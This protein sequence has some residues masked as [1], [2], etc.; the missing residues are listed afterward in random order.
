VLRTLCLLIAPVVD[1]AV[2]KVGVCVYT[3]RFCLWASLRCR[4]LP[5]YRLFETICVISIRVVLVS[6][7]YTCLCRW[8]NTSLFIYIRLLT[9]VAHECILIATMFSGHGRGLLR[10]LGLQWFITSTGE[11]CPLQL[12]HQVGLLPYSCLAVTPVLWVVVMVH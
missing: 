8:G 5:D 11:V 7:L 4:C 6:W 1:M 3:S 9:N 2:W 10:L 12:A